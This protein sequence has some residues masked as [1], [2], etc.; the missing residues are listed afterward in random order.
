MCDPVRLAHH[1]P[2]WH[3]HFDSAR[4]RI[5]QAT[6]GWIVAVEHVG[7]TSLSGMISTPVI[8]MV[9]G[10][11][12]TG[13]LTPA[14][15][16]LEAQHYRRLPLPCWARDFGE[17]VVSN[18]SG[19]LSHQ[20]F[21]TIFDG[22]LWRRMVAVRDRFRQ[23][24]VEARRFEDAKVHRWRNCACRP[25]LYHEGKAM[26]FTHLEEQITAGART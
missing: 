20:I 15:E 14:A 26:F 8:D 24:P 23:N 19:A 9:A 12:D 4:S 16:L 5:L 6:Q 25:Q 10:V 21:L 17:L 13:C 11:M 1:D 22:P 18:R 7:S 3:C 2:R